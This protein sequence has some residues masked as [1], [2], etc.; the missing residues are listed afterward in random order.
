M[1][2]A[3]VVPSRAAGGPMASTKSVPGCLRPSRAMKVI[4]SS[5]GHRLVQASKDFEHDPVHV[6]RTHEAAFEDA[7]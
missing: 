2:L 3:A 4:G 5:R 1:T 7:G 6:D